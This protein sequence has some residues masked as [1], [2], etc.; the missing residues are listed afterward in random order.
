MSA[1]LSPA[2]LPEALDLLARNA[3]AL[4]LAGGTD[5]L[6][7]RRSGAV[8]E[9]RPL[10]ALDRLAEL[11]GVSV[12]REC[13]AI[14][15][16]TSF[17][18]LIGSPLVAAHAP[19][20]ASAARTVGGPALRNRASL[21][22]NLCTASPAGDSL[23]PLAVLAAEVELMSAH[24]RRVLSVDEFITGPGKTAL[25]PGELL[26]RVFIPLASA[27]EFS[28][29]RFE[30]VGRRQSMA[31]SVTSFCGGLR[32]QDD[33]CITSARF[34]WGSV[35][36]TVVR[37]PAVEKALLGERLNAENIGA[38]AE[39]ARAGVTPISDD[40]ASAEYRRRLAGNLLARFLA[41]VHA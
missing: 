24:G 23:P 4:P 13:L 31:I 20:L 33:G 2:T 3:D 8:D 14:G 5:L 15:A 11:H 18:A 40:R 17:S 22:G 12:E 36:P 32:I 34:A 21:G 19:V 9:A 37:L 10:L 39:V 28:H 7:R 30:K 38:A 1:F 25:R 29:Q 27:S 16:A 26:C 41:G 6:V 35:G